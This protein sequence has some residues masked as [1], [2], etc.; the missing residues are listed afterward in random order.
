M[1]RPLD[2]VSAQQIGSVHLQEVD[3]TQKGCV[4]LHRSDD[5]LLKNGVFSAMRNLLLRDLARKTAES[6]LSG[7]YS[8]GRPNQEELAFNYAPTP[9]EAYNSVK[10]II[11]EPEAGVSS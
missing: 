5:E 4:H 8:R 6:P 7:I 1:C 9:G 11:T 2:A 3:K 10:Y